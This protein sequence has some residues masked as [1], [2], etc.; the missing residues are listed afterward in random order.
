MFLSKLVKEETMK[1]PSLFGWYRILRAQYQ[2]RVF[3]AIRC[4]LWLAR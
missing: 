2:F 1:L 3:Q 4:A